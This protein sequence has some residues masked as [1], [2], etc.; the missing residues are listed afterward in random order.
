MSTYMLKKENAK[1]NWYIV[2][3]QSRPLGRLA[4]DVAL[5]LSGKHKPDYTPHV[6]CGDH[7]VVVNAAKIAVTGRKREQNVY[8]RHSGWVGGLKEVPW[9]RLLV[10]NPGK[11][12]MLAIAGMLPKNSIGR[13]SLTRVRV[14]A[15]AEHDQQAQNPTPWDRLR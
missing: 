7:V 4:G 8:R 13:K 15:G 2:D 12:I 1:H 6:D 5:L 11:V 14:Y 3:A 10:D 9:K